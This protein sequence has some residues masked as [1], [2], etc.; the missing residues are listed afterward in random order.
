MAPQDTTTTTQDLLNHPDL[1]PLLD[2]D[3]HGNVV[4]FGWVSPVY[5]FPSEGIDDL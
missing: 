4:C 1:I 2:L 5:Y 3:A